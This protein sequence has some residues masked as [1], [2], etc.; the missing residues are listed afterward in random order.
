MLGAEVVIAVTGSAGPDPQERP[1]GTM[2]IGV[3]TPENAMARTVTM[4]GDRER[5]RTYTST[6]AL[7]LARLAIT[8]KWWHGEPRRG[9]WI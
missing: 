8:G 5:I 4:P 2:V 1:V 6:G 7:H 3:R 9:R